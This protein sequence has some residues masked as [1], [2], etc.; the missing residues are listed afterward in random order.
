VDG[1]MMDRVVVS[2]I[3]MD[4][5]GAPIFLRLGNRARPFKKDMEKPGIGVMRNITIS[6]IEATGANPTGCAICGLPEAKIE[7]VTLSNVRLS[8]EGGGT[9]TDAARPIPEEPT[10]Y[11]EYRMFG[12]LPA[13]GFYGRHV[14]GLKLLNV[15]LQYQKPDQR[16][17]L[18]LD[19]VEDALI[20]DLDAPYSP[21]AEAIVQLTD[22][23]DIFVRGCRPKAGTGVFLKVEGTK[24]K[25]IVLTGNDFR[26]AANVVEQTAGV[27]TK[28]VSEIA[29]LVD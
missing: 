23:R 29:N 6:N 9:K 22:A 4:N 27:P 24:S 10:A 12:K 19:D 2:N 18:I 26:S 13:Y 17:A 7:N 3:T 16:H 28:A 1:G 8:F 14:K 25:G 15:Q 20:D 5:V 21:G 11:P